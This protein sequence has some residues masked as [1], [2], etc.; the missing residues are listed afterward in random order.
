MDHGSAL[1]GHLSLGA[2]NR[3]SDIHGERGGVMAVFL[4]RGVRGEEMELTKWAHS[5]ARMCKRW[6]VR[7]RGPNVSVRVK[8]TQAQS[9]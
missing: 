7:R 8:G 5:A 4:L 6:L 1:P 2:V 9:G 3:I